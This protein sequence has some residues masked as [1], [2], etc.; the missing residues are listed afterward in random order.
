MRQK[1]ARQKPNQAANY[2]G[3][4]VCVV[5]E[6]VFLERVDFAVGKAGDRQGDFPC[7]DER[8]LGDETWKYFGG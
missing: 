6:L 4:V 3:P 5:R 7:G 1:V 2:L 8:S